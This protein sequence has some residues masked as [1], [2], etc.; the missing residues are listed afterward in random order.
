MKN[1]FV[2]NIPENAIYHVGISGGKDS[3]AVLLW[4]VHESGIP[5]HQINATFCDTGNEHEHTYE[6]VR[7]LHEQVHPIE[8]LH[9]VIKTRDP[10]EP[11][12][13]SCKSGF[14]E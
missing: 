5:R 9:H 10:D 1:F 2:P 6:Q 13:I 11:E 14:C 7:I 3:G 8:T 12:P 4:L